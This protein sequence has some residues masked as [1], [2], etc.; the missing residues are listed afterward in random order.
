MTAL[1]AQKVNLTVVAPRLGEL[2]TGVQA[3]ASYITT[4]EFACTLS[5]L[6]ESLAI[7]LVS[8]E[9]PL[10]LI[11]FVTHSFRL[12]RRDSVGGRHKLQQS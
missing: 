8:S 10:I 9:A 4:S 3:G 1:S 11:C 5:Q 2:K 7:P 6:D 12:L